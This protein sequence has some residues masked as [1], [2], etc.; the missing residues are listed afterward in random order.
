MS[1]LLSCHLLIEDD[2]DEQEILQKAIN[3]ILENYK[4]EH[5]TI[6]IEKSTLEHSEFKV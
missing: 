1:D 4:I 3:L 6:Q 2:R 5:T